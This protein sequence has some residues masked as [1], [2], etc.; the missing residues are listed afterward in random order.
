MSQRVPATG[1]LVVCVSP[2]VTLTARQPLVSVDSWIHFCAAPAL[3]GLY[4][5]GEVWW[6]R[7]VLARALMLAFCCWGL[8]SGS[9]QWLVIRCLTSHFLQHRIDF[10]WTA[11]IHGGYRPDV[12]IMNES[13]HVLALVCILSV[14]SSL[15]SYT[16]LCF[17]IP[18]STLHLVLC[19]E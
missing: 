9:D 10:C 8:V 3:N 1:R 15:R 5:L 19:R 18:F 11:H 7:S 14:W 16:I 12:N 4:S 17:L 13:Q 6:K 2:L